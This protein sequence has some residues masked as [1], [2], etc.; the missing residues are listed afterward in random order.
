MIYL[1]THVVAWL[2]A[3]RVDLLPSEAKDRIEDD[4]ILVSPMVCLEFEYLFEIERVAESAAPV[5]AALGSTLGLAVCD[6]PFPV[7]A[8]TARS[9]RWT[10]DPFDR[11]IVAQALSRSAELVTKNAVIHENVSIAVWA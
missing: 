5:I 4:D 8:E 9:Q 11:I 10:R 2:Y 3:G 6:L 7:V 1:D